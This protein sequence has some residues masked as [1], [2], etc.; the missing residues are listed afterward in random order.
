MGYERYPRNNAGSQY[1]RDRESYGHD[2]GSGREFSYSSARDYE[3][4]GMIGPR[5]GDNRQRDDFGGD[6]GYYSQPRE[7]GRGQ[8]NQY[9][10]DPDDGRRY[11]V[12]GNRNYG[13]D[14]YRD[15]ARG[16]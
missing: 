13:R 10:Y 4:A 7:Y 14:M 1:D 15:Q 2:Y 16:D 9:G 6:R 8:S 3:A 12:S 5:G 11:T